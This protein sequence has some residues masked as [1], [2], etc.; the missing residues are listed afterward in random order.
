MSGLRLVGV[1]K[2]FGAHPLMHG[3]DLE[4]ADGEFLVLVGASGCGK[5]T[6]LAEVRCVLRE[7]GGRSARQPAAAGLRP[8]AGA[9]FRC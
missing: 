2:R 4:V 9:S 3:V 6:L 5:S 1:S 8:R 7:R